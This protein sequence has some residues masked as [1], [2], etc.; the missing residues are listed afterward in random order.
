M[1]PQVACDLATVS[2]RIISRHIVYR[3]LAETGLFSSAP[4]LSYPIMSGVTLETESAKMHFAPNV[5]KLNF[6]GQHN[7]L[8]TMEYTPLAHMHTDHMYEA[9][10]GLFG[11]RP[12]ILLPKE[13]IFESA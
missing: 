13:T 3:H 9:H 7:A 2:G 4:F 10:L 8:L 1:V 11:L 12:F 6:F 5:E